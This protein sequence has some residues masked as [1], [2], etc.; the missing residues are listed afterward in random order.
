MRKE[1]HRKRRVFT[2]WEGIVTKWKK[3]ADR[4]ADEAHWQKEKEL[5]R[6]QKGKEGAERKAQ[7]ENAALK[8]IHSHKWRQCVASDYS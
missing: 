3:N 5:L 8:Q 1:K 2:E 6:I 4:R 7:K